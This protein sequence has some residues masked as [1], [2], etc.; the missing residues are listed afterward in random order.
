M[1]TGSDS[2]RRLNLVKSQLRRDKNYGEFVKIVY[3]KTEQKFHVIL[4][5]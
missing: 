4:V 2:F 3:F 1:S 5:K